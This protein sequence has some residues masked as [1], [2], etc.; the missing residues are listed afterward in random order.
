LFVLL[1]LLLLESFVKLG[2]GVIL[3]G[4]ADWSVGRGMIAL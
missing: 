3:E 2:D 1:Q 4:S